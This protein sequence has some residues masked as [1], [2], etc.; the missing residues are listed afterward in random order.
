MPTKEILMSHPVS[1]LRAEI[2]KANLSQKAD[3]NLF[4]RAVSKMRKDELIAVMLAPAYKDRFH[5]IKMREKPVGK[6]PL[7]KVRYPA[8]EKAKSAAVADSDDDA[9]APKKKRAPRR[10]TTPVLEAPSFSS[11]P[12]PKKKKGKKKKA[13]VT[14]P[15]GKLISAEAAKAAKEA[16]KAAKAA[17][18]AKDAA[19]EA[20]RLS[21]QK[22]L[23]TTK[24]DGTVVQ[25]PTGRKARR[26]AEKKKTVGFAFKR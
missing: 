21:K 5:H 19:E 3:K 17:K 23:T 16:A 12:A 20:K 8:V 13:L 11:A 22:P 25:T 7:K 15:S 2:A 4:K 6:K 9:P 14:L 10:P 24:A 1:T 18:S 26:A